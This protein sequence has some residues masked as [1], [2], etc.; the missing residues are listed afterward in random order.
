MKIRDIFYPFVFMVLFFAVS[1]SSGNGLEGMAM[2]RLP[3]AL[4]KAMEEQMSLKGGAQIQ[5]PDIIYDSDSLCMIQFKAV[6]KDPSGKKFSFP[7]RYIYLRDVFMSAA[8]GHPIYLE[9]VTGCQ[10]M[11]RKELKT[12]KESCREKSNELYIYYAGVATP[13]NPEDIW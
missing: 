1:C 13:I 6:A 4:E 10:T 3:K 12:L 8:K 5:S 7:V 9:M 11:N 2:E